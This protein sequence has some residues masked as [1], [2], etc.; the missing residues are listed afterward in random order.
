L[1]RKKTSSLHALHHFITVYEQLK[2][3]ASPSASNA[4]PYF[5]M[6][7]YF[8]RWRSRASFPTELYS[9]ESLGVTEGIDIIAQERFRLARAG[10]V[11]PAP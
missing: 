4:N 8:F 5:T 3:Q 2:L 11:L 10:E 9:T 7:C 1:P 6:N